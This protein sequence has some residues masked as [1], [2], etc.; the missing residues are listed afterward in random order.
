MEN[1][2]ANL[3]TTVLVVLDV[4]SEFIETNS[5][6]EEDGDACPSGDEEPGH[7]G[8]RWTGGILFSRRNSLQSSHNY[9][10]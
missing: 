7:V 3:V 2:R 5:D 10:H 8:F 1:L 9:H 4:V 6:D